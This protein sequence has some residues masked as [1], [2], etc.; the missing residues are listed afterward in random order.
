[1]QE[2]EPLHRAVASGSLRTVSAEFDRNALARLGILA[3]WLSTCG[4]LPG[5]DNENR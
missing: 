2:G 3:P 1:V 4:L 5:A